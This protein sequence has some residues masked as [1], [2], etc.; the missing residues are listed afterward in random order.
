MCCLFKWLKMYDPQTNMQSAHVSRR[1]V[2]K[3]FIL[4]KMVAHFSYQ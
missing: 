4:L 1:K 3:L 2:E